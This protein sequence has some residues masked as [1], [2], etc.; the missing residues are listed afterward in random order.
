MID[1]YRSDNV[2]VRRVPAQ[3]VSRWVVT[4]D[5]YGLGPGFDRPGFGQDFLARSGVSA[6]HVLGR[7]DDWYQYPDMAQA[8]AAV[9]GAVAGAERVMTYGSS[10]GAYA[11]IRFADAVGAHAA[12]AISPQYSIDPRRAPFEIRWTADAQRIDFQPEIEDRLACAIRPLI[13]YDSAGDDQR[14]VA[15]IAAEISADLIGVGHIHHPATTFL[16]EAGMLAP[17]V[18]ELLAGPVDAAALMARARRARRDSVACLT[19]MAERQ[20]PHRPRLALALARRAVEIQPDQPMAL[21]GLAQQL[22]R[23]GDHEAALTLHDRAT[24]LSGRGISYL[25][26]YSQALAAA[27]RLEDAEALA[28]E[29]V[30]QCPSAPHLHYWLATIR[31]RAG[32]TPDAIP[33][34]ERAVALEPDNARYRRTL[35]EQ[36][37]PGGRF[38]RRLFRWLKRRLA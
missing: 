14:H 28:M 10:M 19:L 31:L 11:A 36:Q 16:L 5:N 18:M 23:A 33:A 6:I 32:R 37:A 1:L 30:E 22:T 20:P 27:G 4:F 2:V 38:A 21:S 15:L 9:R 12:L 35:A 29:A 8:L 7:G 17:L 24:R 25:A 34:L 26:P 13:V 3:D